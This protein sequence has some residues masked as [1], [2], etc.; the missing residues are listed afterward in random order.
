MTLVDLMHA[1][2]VVTTYG[3][4]DIRYLVL[5]IGCLILNAKRIAHRAKRKEPKI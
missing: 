1:C 3:I 5:G 4:L 2:T